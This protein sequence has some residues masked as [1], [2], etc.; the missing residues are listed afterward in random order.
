MIAAVA[1][2]GTA[3]AFV[4]SLRQ[5]DEQYEP[6]LEI[7]KVTSYVT[8][9]LDGYMVEVGSDEKIPLEKRVRGPKI[10]VTLRNLAGG[11]S[12]ITGVAATVREVHQLTPCL[13]TGGHDMVSAYYDLEL[14][15]PVPATPFVLKKEGVRFHVPPNDYER[16]AFTVGRG[17]DHP[18]VAVLDVELTHDDGEVLR[19]GP[20][21][22]VEQ[23]AAGSFNHDEKGK[24]TID[25]PRE[26]GSSCLEDNLAIV[27]KVLSTDGLIAPKE[28]VNLQETLG[29]MIPRS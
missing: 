7:A 10:D 16:F 25:P 28:L 12:M 17:D 9:D 15:D 22:V 14:P 1:G 2:V 3:A 24:W 23:G 20:I 19:M 13:A 29:A 21:A 6:D 18:W 11:A 26:P 8:Y 4:L 5:Y 27:K